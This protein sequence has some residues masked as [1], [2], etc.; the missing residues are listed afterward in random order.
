M[1]LRSERSLPPSLL[2]GLILGVVSVVHGRLREEKKRKREEEEQRLEEEEKER[3]EKILTSARDEKA[4][5]S[6]KAT[7][8]DKSVEE[9][10]TKDE[11]NAPESEEQVS[12]REVRHDQAVEPSQVTL[13]PVFTRA[14]RVIS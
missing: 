4:R 10:S 1:T 7:K 12:E 13:Y 5:E 3:R 2:H 6:A 11:T 14:L 9:A 8:G